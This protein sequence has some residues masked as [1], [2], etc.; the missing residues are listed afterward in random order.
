MCRVDGGATRAGMMLLV[1][2]IWGCTKPVAPVVSGAISNGD[3]LVAMQ[4]AIES[5]AF[6]RIEAVLVQQGGDVRF[7]GY[8]RRTGPE[9]RI[10]A[11]SAGKSITALAAG[12]AVD[13]GVL[14][15]D[16]AAFDHL[17]HLAPFEN[18]EG[19]EQILV[20]DLLTMS[21]SLDCSDWRQSPGNEERMYRRRSWAR[22]AVD[23]PLDPAY[24]RSPT[25]QGRFSYCT[26]GAFLMG[27]VLEHVTEQPFDAFVQER[28]FAPLGIVD[29]VWTRS[30]TGEVQ[31]GGQLSLRARDFLALGN[32]VRHR[33]EHDGRTLVS[34]EW[35][36]EMLHPKVQATPVQ[37]YGYL[38]WL[39]GFRVGGEGEPRGGFMMSGNGGN[40][41][42]WL[43]DYD[44]TVVILAT[45][46][47]DRDMHELTTTLIE[48]YIL[49][50]LA[51]AP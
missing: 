47:N 29:P 34:W 1:W 9:T 15:V 18:P 50:A 12:V 39:Y 49:P 35:I 32:L 51:E 33:G 44:A 27:R 22:F 8:Y 7:E 24:R 41:V 3:P 6:R 5:G 17:Q 45:N 42:V 30:P 40:K 14:S 26:A 28:L 43:P 4:A 10:D 11:R 23:L 2:L 37:T 16:D 46:Y 21:S 20:R 13:E 31:S 48:R 25:G 19:K 36:Q 38:W